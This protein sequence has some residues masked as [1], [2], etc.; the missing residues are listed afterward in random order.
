MT[1]YRPHP[2]ARMRPQAI[3]AI[4]GWAEIFREQ[5]LFSV[6]GDR[7]WNCDY[8]ELQQKIHAKFSDT[9]PTTTSV[10]ATETRAPP[11]AAA[12]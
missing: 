6:C 9:R 1:A 3:P 2:T 12:A 7:A 10:T 8:A 11:P 4:L 5:R